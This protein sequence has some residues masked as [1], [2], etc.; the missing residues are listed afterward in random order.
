MTKKKVEVPYW[1]AFVYC[2]NPDTNR[3]SGSFL[4]FWA[5]NRFQALQAIRAQLPTNP[6]YLD[7][8]GKLRDFTLLDL[9]Q[10]RPDESAEWAMLFTTFF[11]EQFGGNSP[12]CTGLSA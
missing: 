9:R 3:L 7:A 1:A 2:Y 8:S 6:E 11:S 4:S 5:Q 12:A 10:I